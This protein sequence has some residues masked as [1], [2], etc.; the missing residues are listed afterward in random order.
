MGLHS[1]IARSILRRIL[2]LCFAKSE[3]IPILVGPLART[4]LPRTV[5]LSN[6]SLVFS[7]YEPSVTSE[8]TDLPSSIRVAYDI[9]AHVGL[10][11]LTL[12]RKVGPHGTVVAFEPCPSNVAP[13]RE[14]VRQNGLEK[15]VEVLDVAVA[16]YDGE[17]LL[18][19]GDTA[20]MHKLEVVHEGMSAP[21]R[22]TFTARVTSIDELVFKQDYPP[23]QLIKVDVEGAEALV[24]K[25]ARETL[26]QYA[27][28]LLLEIHGPANVDAIWDLLSDLSY[29][30]KALGDSGSPEVMTRQRARSF[31]S[32][33]LWTHHFFWQC[34]LL[35]PR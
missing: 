12:A 14:L 5:A 35:Q 30:W 34:G 3:S 27:P 8:I 26:K 1:P 11:T 17:A 19:V 20:Y 15:V 28:Y 29:E 32:K 10:M 16:D 7:R 2:S 22:Q 24:I 33:E 25:G 13:L 23:P 21:S 6:L 4:R 18:L 31:F 9:G